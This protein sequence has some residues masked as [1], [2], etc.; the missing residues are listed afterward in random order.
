M[1]FKLS[2][3]FF[4]LRGSNGSFKIQGDAKE[5]LQLF[6]RKIIQYLI[7]NNT[8]IDSMFP[9]ITTINLCFLHAIFH[10]HLSML[11]SLKHIKC[12]IY[13]LYIYVCFIKGNI[14]TCNLRH[15]NWLEVQGRELFSCLGFF[16]RYLQESK[17]RPA[18]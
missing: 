14:K 13:A 17:H 16:Y 1:K 6:V 7:K 8:R 4:L 18:F 12:I 5:G 11:L 15:L 2:I 10:I 9:I 3:K